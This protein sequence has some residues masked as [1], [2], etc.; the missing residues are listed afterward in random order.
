MYGAQRDLPHHPRAAVRTGFG[1]EHR[2]RAFTLD[3]QRLHVRA[4]MTC[5]EAHHDVAIRS[6][7]VAVHSVDRRAVNMLSGCRQVDCEF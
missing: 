4:A 1:R 2:Q 7:V 6:G 5:L 3:E